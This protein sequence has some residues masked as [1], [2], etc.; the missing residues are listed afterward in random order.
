MF[1]PADEPS[2]GEESSPQEGDNPDI[3][4]DEMLGDGPSV[5]AS[6]RAPAA[7]GEPHIYTLDG[8]AFDFQAV[9]EFVFAQSSLGGFEIQGRTSPY[10]GAS[11]QVSMNTAFGFRVAE[12]EVSLVRQTSGE[13]EVRI[14]DVA[15]EDRGPRELAG[16]GLLEIGSNS[17]L[18]SWPDGASAEV[19]SR[20]P[21]LD[22]YVGLPERY[23]NTMSGVLGNYDGDPK[24]DLVTAAGQDLGMSPM[25]EQLYGMYAD[26]WRISEKNALFHRK[27]DTDSTE[28]YTDQTF[29]QLSLGV[30]GLNEEA[31]AF[32]EQACREV[33]NDAIF[34]QCVFDVGAT[35]DLT[36]V[37]S[38]RVAE[39]RLN[40]PIV[41]VES[42]SEVM[43]PMPFRIDIEGTF[44]G[45]A[46]VPFEPEAEN[47][48]N[49]PVSLTIQR[50]PDNWLTGEFEY[51]TL[52]CSGSL[53]FIFYNGTEAVGAQ[54]S[55]SEPGACEQGL[56]VVIGIPAQFLGVP[57]PNADPNVVQVNWI[58]DG[59][60]PIFRAARLTRQ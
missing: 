31:V 48:V 8:L 47:E 13:I 40:T 54:E 15:Y 26:G 59:S 50:N 25:P 57:D 45:V 19:V 4:V 11:L 27:D 49:I 14:D 30:S 56:L 10:H 6:E 12:A 52:G 23:R 7:V 32:A 9:G 34:D 42:S 58:R 18:L 53:V 35:G 29:P 39:A 36:F 37:D 21:F 51:P 46:T 28:D 33:T 17:W 41:R 24:N 44:S 2:D 1:D 20:G 16:G 60:N 22:L 3:V 5:P 43:P 38:A 55:F